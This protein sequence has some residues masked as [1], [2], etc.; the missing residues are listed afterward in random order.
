MKM[1]WAKSVGVEPSDLSAWSII[2]C[3]SFA[4]VIASFA[5]Y[6]HE[7]LR[8]RQQRDRHGQHSSMLALI[9]AIWRL[10]GL[11]GFYRGLTTNLLRVVPAG[12]ITFVTFE[13]VSKELMSLQRRS[14]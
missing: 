13:H 8:T 3:S 12:A 10:E 11:A 4:K 5:A 1:R 9:R 14:L 7:V 6:P 2:A